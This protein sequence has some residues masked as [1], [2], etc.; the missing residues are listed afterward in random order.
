MTIASACCKLFRWLRRWAAARATFRIRAAAGGCKDAGYL[1]S[2]VRMD[3]KISSSSWPSNGDC[4]Q[5]RSITS[6]RT[7]S[8]VSHGYLRI[9]TLAAWRYLGQQHLVEQY[10][11]RPPVDGPAVLDFAEDL[12][13]D[14]QG[15][16]L[17]IFNGGQVWHT[18]LTANYGQEGARTSG[19]INSGVPQN[20]LVRPS[21]RSSGLHRP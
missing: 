19:A 10:A 11:K 1:I 17:S 6:K 9:T 12:P 8:C 5:S 7:P 13:R 4:H 3:R 16:N 2:A 21:M 15:Y 20:V 14:D 18:M